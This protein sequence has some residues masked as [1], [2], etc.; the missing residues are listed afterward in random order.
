MPTSSRN[1]TERSTL[2]GP[3]HDYDAALRLAQR[4]RNSDLPKILALLRRAVAANYGPAEYA[5]GTWYLFGV[6]VPKNRKRAAELFRR[7]AAKGVADAAYDLAVSYELG[8]GVSKSSSK[9]FQL[10]KRAAR[11]GDHKAEYEVGRCYC[12]GIGVRRDQRRAEFW[13]SRARKHKVRE[14]LEDVRNLKAS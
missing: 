8:V 13:Y 4:K 12:W 2:T 3:Q 1:R 10:Y 14:A 9:A 7:A 5:L 6:A 11:L